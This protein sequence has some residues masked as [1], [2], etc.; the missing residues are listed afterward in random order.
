MAT[1]TKTAGTA[2]TAGAGNDL[3]QLP[4]LAAYPGGIDGGFGVDELRWNG[5][6]G[7]VL[8]LYGGLVAVEMVA[9]GTG[10]AAVADASGTADASVDAGGLAY[11]LRIVGN[12]GDNSLRGGGAA[13]VL[14]GGAGDDSL[15]GGAGDDSLSGGAGNDLLD[16]GE[17]VDRLDGGLG[18]DTY[19]L[20]EGD[21][22]AGEGSLPGGGYDTLVYFGG[23]AV[24]LVPALE[25]LVLAQGSGCVALAGA[26]EDG[27]FQG[28]GA[29]N[30][31]DAGGGA[32]ELYGLGGNDVLVGGAGDDLLDGGRGADLMVGGAG[33]DLYVVDTFHDRVVEAPGQGI[34]V[35]R[36]WLFRY[37]LPE[38]L[39]DLVLEDGARQGTGNGLANVLEGNGGDNLLSGLG[40]A[41]TL[42]GG[43]GDDTLNGGM[44][45]DLLEGG[46]GSDVAVFSGR[47]GE[48]QVTIGA[49]GVTVIG[50]EGTDSL[51]DIET[52]RFDDRQQIVAVSSLPGAGLP[53]SLPA[54]VTE[55]LAD[56]YW[57]HTS[58]VP[59]VLHFSFMASV[60]DYATKPL[61]L[62]T[63]SPM[64]EGQKAAVREVLGIYQGFLDI[65]FEEVADAASVELRFG[66]NNQSADGSSG[67][68]YL[69]N[70]N[71][72]TG[73]G[74][75]A[76][77]DVW[78]AADQP[79]TGVIPGEFVF[80]TLLHE[81]G[82]ALG[83][84]HP[85]ESP[86][87]T[88]AGHPDED[89][90]RF[91]MMSYTPRDHAMVV[92]L[93]A[94]ISYDWSAETPMLYDIAV[95]QG[96]YGA[97]DAATDDTILPPADRPFLR[98]VWDGG[99]VDTLDTSAFGNGSLVDLRPGHFSTVDN[100]LGV[101]DG[102][103][104][105]ADIP[106]GLSP[107][108]TYG[109]DNLAIAY[110]TII[111][112]AVGGAGAD[113]LIGNSAA[114]TLTGGAGAD[115]FVFNDPGAVDAIADFV[116][117][118]DRLVFDRG[119]FTALGGA[120]SLV[121]GAFRAGSSAVEADDRLLYDGTTGQLYYDADGSGPTAAIQVA[122][123]A[124][125]PA[126]A[127]ADILVA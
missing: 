31:I 43:E 124:G 47:Y 84:K 36:S 125:I 14:E 75:G 117:G 52:L 90:T 9:I 109:P 76:A 81:I 49:S 83:L 40:G 55:T 92:D 54:Y 78:L 110:G 72:A 60:P 98:T 82:H 5:A 7:E 115:R 108:P 69:P 114:N 88:E 87:L 29:A 41:D 111:E 74:N 59:L 63:F 34:D 77:G 28:N 61:E 71:Q 56:G 70:A 30:F 46:G 42:R 80:E 105:S 8:V 22:V 33:D 15:R 116:P 119:A 44:G 73:T 58:G 89:T 11:G 64:S 102:G 4:A 10:D 48:Y 57:A 100:G 16:G 53:T 1:F 85:F 17:G 112:K 79:T 95:L 101:F 96:L 23:G 13:D 97:N 113:T 68:A 21:V 51:R 86:S 127:A 50:P 107:Q 126:L 19:Y 118:T 66:R 120:G 94:S 39:D 37:T 123:L 62:S 103:H 104:W 67:Y 25:S 3:I 12:A 122:T 45:N 20:Y 2:L 91:T 6:G 32:D 26:G 35:V 27:F 99:G 65:L 38:N 93:D 24:A 106:P 18:D 121:D